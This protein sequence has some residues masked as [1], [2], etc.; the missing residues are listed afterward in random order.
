MMN[1]IANFLKGTGEMKSMYMA[2]TGIASI[3]SGLNI[4][5]TVS[6]GLISGIG[7]VIVAWAGFEIGMALYQHDTAQIPGS[8][9]KVAGG[10]VMIGIGVFIGL[11][12]AA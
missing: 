7:I 8:L 11:F 1:I 3:D 5:K 12:S 4:L 10:L 6:V 9:K 2:G